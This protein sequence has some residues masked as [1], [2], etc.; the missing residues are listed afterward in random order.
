[1]QELKIKNKMRGPF[2]KEQFLKR[3]C[4]VDSKWICTQVKN[5]LFQLQ[6]KKK[7]C[8]IC[9]QKDTWN[10]KTLPLLLHHKN[11]ETF[12]NR[13]ENIE[14]LCPNCFYQ[15]RNN[16]IKKN[17]PNLKRRKSKKDLLGE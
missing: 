13:L 1:M 2:T 7:E 6:I 11:G 15:I 17:N 9:G 4:V 12:D 10:H 5:R 8:E 16:E 14:I 3:V